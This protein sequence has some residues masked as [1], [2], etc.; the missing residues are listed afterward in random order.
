MT[1][2]V[3]I[4]SA[5]EYFEEFGRE[6]LYKQH[7]LKDQVR[8][9]LVDTFQKEIYSLVAM[10]AKK[11][12]NDIPKEGDPEALRIAANVVK[13]ETKKW[14]KVVQMFEQYSET[15]GC[16]KYSDIS[17][18]PEDGNGEIGFQDGKLVTRETV[19]KDGPEE[20][21]DNGNEMA[22]DEPVTSGYVAVQEDISGENAQVTSTEYASSRA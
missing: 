10:R 18:V 7:M 3:R 12:F 8:K 21:D 22:Q 20:V 1:D 6:K 19:M 14:K 4:R 13:D 2:G 15:S 17:M 9:E 11:R 16:I 5:K